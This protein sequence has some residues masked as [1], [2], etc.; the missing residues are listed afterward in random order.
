M[1]SLLRLKRRAVLASLAALS[2][3]VAVACAS[4]NNEGPS[5]TAPAASPAAGN[6]G[7]AVSLSGAGASFPAPLYQRW[8]ADYNKENPNTQIS[9]QSVGSGA[10]V[11][12]FLAGTVDFGASDQPLKDEE[13]AQ[14]REKYGA[15]AIQ[16][17]VT[18]GSI[19]MAYN[20][21]GVDNL[22]LPREVYCGIVTGEIT[23]WNDPAIASANQGTNLP[24]EQIQFVHRSD[25]SGTTFGFTNHLKAACPE[26]KAGANKSV[27]WPVGTGAKGN[28]GVTAQIQQTPGAIGYTEFS[29]AKENGLSMA[30]MENKAGNIIEPT[31]E[32]G[33]LAF[34]GQTVPEDFALLVPDPTDEQ[35]YPITTLTWLLLYPQYQDAAKGEAIKNVVNW[36]LDNG[37]TAASDLG[38]L[39]ADPDLAGRV[40]EEVATI[41]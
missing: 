13:K 6:S 25:G 5:A 18:G 16:V 37:K 36:T 39:P 40:K 21:E 17:P 19:V 28:E 11:E 2:M 20:L 1:T 27:E 9:Y 4:S 8:F 35:A 33:A 41:K 23:Q 29:Y 22:K 7:A 32:A 10:G 3:S 26:W 31:P 34:K 24:N 30:A 15:D 14:F 38:Y 12:Q